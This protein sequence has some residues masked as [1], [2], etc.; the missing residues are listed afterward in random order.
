[1]SG[2]KL[3]DCQQLVSPLSRAGAFQQ[4]YAPVEII[5]LST[6]PTVEAQQEAYQHQRR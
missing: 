2:L 3:N 6:A 1:M 5:D 4:A